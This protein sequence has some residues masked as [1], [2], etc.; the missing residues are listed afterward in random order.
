LV[1]WL[2]DD[3]VGW[4]VGWWMTWW[5]SPHLEKSS[6]AKRRDSTKIRGWWE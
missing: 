4:L 2:V 1:G 3:L 6:A 5:L